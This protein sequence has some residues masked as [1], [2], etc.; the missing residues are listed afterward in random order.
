MSGSETQATFPFAF[1]RLALGA[2]LATLAYAGNLLHFPLF[3]GVDYVF[4]SIAA[5]LAAVWLGPLAGVAAA[6]AGGVYTLEMWGHPWALVIFA[7]EA[8]T[9][10]ILYRRFGE[11][12]LADILFWS[13]IGVPLIFLAYNGALGMSWE[14]TGLIA[15]KQPVNGVFNALMGIGV[16][17]VA[18]KG[19]VTVTLR[20]LVFNTLFGGIF[21]VGLVLI[22]ALTQ[23]L[24]AVEEDL[25]GDILRERRSSV[26]SQ[27]QTAL[28][29]SD[30]EDVDNYSRIATEMGAGL[31]LPDGRLLP[32][33][34]LP[35]WIGRADKRDRGQGVTVRLPPD[36]RQLPA[37]ERWARGYY[38][39]EAPLPTEEG[40][41][42]V[43][44][45][46]SARPVMERLAWANIYAH[47]LLVLVSLVGGLFS[48]FMAA[49]MVRPFRRLEEKVRGLAERIEAGQQPELP[50]TSVWEASQL[51][52]AFEEMAG[53]LEQF[54]QDLAAN[55]AMLE[56]RV[57]ERTSHLAE[58][59]E[60]LQ[61][62]ERRLQRLAEILEATPDFVSFAHPDGTVM[63][64]NQGGRKLMGLSPAPTA[65]GDLTP[66]YLQE[67]RI[68]G[69]WAHS[70]WASRK[71]V[72]EGMPTAIAEGHWEGET[73][74]ID[75]NGR[76]I[77][78][79][80]V[81]VAHY[82]DQ[83]ELSQMSTIMRDIRRN[84]ELE[85]ELAHK[86]SHDPLTGVYNRQQYD[87]LMEQEMER[88]QRYAAPFSLIMLDIDH[89]KMINDSFGHDTGDE[90][91][92][93]LTGVVKGR[94]RTS[95]I[96]ARW[97]GEE[98][99]VLL[100]ETTEAEAAEVA[101]ALRTIV[102]KTDFPCPG[103]I[104]VSAGVTG[105]RSGES[106]SALTKRL[107]DAL[108]QAKESGRNQ[109]AR[110]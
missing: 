58:A 3:F 105:Y 61:D 39:V 41:A 98:F 80:Q 1:P 26:V 109:T 22:A 4:G 60:A 68:A 85:A 16:L 54:I 96:L 71:I 93:A 76:E 2:I 81:I 108:Y 84:K 9:V 28:S 107:D 83:G 44:L 63:Y 70:D 21:L 102:A 20:Q 5:L 43:V 31:I 30:V 104:T 10:G 34:G 66:M 53:T 48:W 73:A 12:A 88:A 77:P 67:S 100:P 36:E 49:G 91:L 24:H 50:T 106:Q 90:V 15:L 56:E 103:R 19:R 82:D 13:V 62:R 18:G 8:G 75:V 69:R 38:T 33:R 46:Q 65:M 110:K 14:S 64:V 11:L 55:Q 89:F 37:M 72:E 6:A 45:T 57:R 97:G 79:S 47:G 40:V 101:E 99:M 95:D 51:G 59:N 94:L 32:P 7:L 86:A 92:V 25:V 74:L 29:E 17:Y 27:V 35:E 42:A 23:T 78:V 52:A 87:L